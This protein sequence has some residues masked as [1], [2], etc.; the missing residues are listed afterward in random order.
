MV[1]IDE[2]SAKELYELAK[3]KEREE[4]RLAQMQEQ[5]NELKTRREQ[6]IKRH[7]EELAY[8]DRKLEE[9]NAQRREMIESH[10]KALTAL[11]Q[12]L[13]KAQ[14]QCDT[15]RAAAR[16]IPEAKPALEK[17]ELPPPIAEPD[18]APAR[19][20]PKAKGKSDG[21]ELEV[22][23]SHIHKI[24]KGRSYISE[25]LLRERLT[26][27]NFKSPHLSKL[28]DTLV[29]QTKLVRR[30]GGNYV[31]GKGAKKK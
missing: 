27:L 26:Q 15:R 7:Q 31:L 24:M 10:Q 13:R 21:D 16:A 9:L 14:E 22:L 3:Q 20:T 4:E 2:L 23:M 12:E 17:E 28:L 30:T 11:E 29:R 8:T 5:L 6:L 1:N 25:S 18:E 19:E